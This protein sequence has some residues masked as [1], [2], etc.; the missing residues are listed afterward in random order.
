MIQKNASE[1]DNISNLYEKEVYPTDLLSLILLII[2]LPFGLLLLT[3][4]LLIIIILLPASSQ[5]NLLL[6]CICYII[7]LIPKTNKHT[8]CFK[9]TIFISNHVT[10]FDFLLLKSR[11]SDLKLIENNICYYKSKN[12]SFLNKILLS[13]TVKCKKDDDNQQPLCSFPEFEST[14]GKYGLLDFNVD[15]F[16][17]I[18]IN[19]QA[20]QLVP[21]CLSVDYYLLPFSINYKYSNILT[22]FLCILF[23]PAV[24]YNVQ[25]LEPIQLNQDENL[26]GKD[27]AK[28]LQAKIGSKLNLKCTS[29]TVNDYNNMINDINQQVS[30]VKVDDLENDYDINKLILQINEILP[31]M[32]RDLIRDYIKH[33]KTLDIDSLITGLLEKISLNHNDNKQPAKLVEQVIVKNKPK[34][35][36]TYPE[37]KSLMIDEARQRFLMKES[38]KNNFQ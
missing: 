6:K 14:N 15:I 32:S 27:L 17:S 23:A 37:R 36:L 33:A 38:L 18:L 4:R 5:N 24:S 20:N 9:D 21:V 26:A 13:S 19:K 25:F 35:I 30:S 1:L 28:Q 11:L 8:N 2:Y 7:G 29:F 12:F 34:K 10:C 22:Q 31:D 16:D 3:I